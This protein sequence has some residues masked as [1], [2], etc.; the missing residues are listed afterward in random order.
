MRTAHIFLLILLSGTGWRFAGAKTPHIEMRPKLLAAATRSLNTGPVEDRYTSADGTTADFRGR[1]LPRPVAGLVRTPH[2][3]PQMP[4][5]LALLLFG[6]GLFGA[7]GLCI[8]QASRVKR[9][10]AGSAVSY[11]G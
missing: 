9:D 6:S 5:P 10:K 3:D 4:E 1:A 8:H 7:S 2:F 11:S